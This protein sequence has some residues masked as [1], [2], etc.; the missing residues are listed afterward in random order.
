MATSR[1]ARCD[2]DAIRM[3][4]GCDHDAIRM[5]SGYDQDVIRMSSGCDQAHTISSFAHSP[6]YTSPSANLHVPCPSASPAAL[7]FPL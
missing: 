3:R 1:S 4:S 2:Q 6:V 7:R 5:P